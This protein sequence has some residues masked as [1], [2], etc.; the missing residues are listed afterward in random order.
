MRN[1]HA[2]VV[3]S[4]LSM[5]AGAGGHAEEPQ[6]FPAG[7]YKLDAKGR[8]ASTPA[9]LV[10]TDE[11]GPGHCQAERATGIYKWALVAIH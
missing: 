8:Y 9:Y 11:D 10:L 5:A 4:I 3:L 1:G 7:V 2:I 6:P